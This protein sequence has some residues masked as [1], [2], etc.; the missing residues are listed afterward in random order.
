MS[1][2]KP[3]RRAGVLSRREFGVLMHLTSLPDATRWG[4]LGR[5][6]DHFLDWLELAGAR[7]W[8]VLPL[9]PVGADGSPY[10]ARSTHAG[11]PRLIDLEALEVDGAEIARRADEPFAAWHTRVVAAATLALV[12]RDEPAFRRWWDEEVHW[13]DDYALAVALAEEYAAPCWWQWPAALRDREPTAVQSARER[14]AQRIAQLAAEQYLFHSQWRSLKSRAAVRGIRLFGD[15]P[16]YLAPDAVDVWVHRDLFELDASGRPTAVA[17]VPPDYF[18]V[19][20]QLWGN[21]VYRWSEH[22][23]T[24]FAWWLDRLGA[25]L[26]LCDFVRLDHFRALESFW[27][28]PAGMTARDGEWRKADGAGLLA[29]A[30]ERFA[31]LPI[32]AEDLGVITPAVEALRDAFGLP[33]MRVLQFA[34]DGDP[35]NVHL[36]HHWHGDLVAYTGTHDNDTL[37]GWLAGLD[38]ASRERVRAYVGSDSLQEGLLR[39]L[40]GSVAGLAIIPMQD[41][42][43]LG[44]EA[45]MNVPGT[46]GDNWRWQLDWPV[47]APDLAARTRAMAACFGRVPSG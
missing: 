14:H 24:G 29:A 23:R 9:G 16:M 42:V 40:F 37:A 11:N 38:P 3:S 17:G 13:L 4:A 27:S 15:L 36:P 34:F 5:A 25:E 19:D 30:R 21:P 45:R 2:E 33:G 41:L 12:R 10:Y 18:A 39:V 44:S 26:R 6:A 20:G 46:V 35:A 1:T 32:V 7:V 8:Q 28:V 22:R 47:V 31:S 43:G